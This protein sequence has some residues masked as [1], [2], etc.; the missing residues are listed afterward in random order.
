MQSDA[1]AYTNDMKA[2]ARRLSQAADKLNHAGTRAVAAYLFGLAA[3]CALKALAAGLP[4]GTAE[5][6]QYTH[7]PALRT[8]LRQLQ[9]GR[10]AAPLR[11]LVESD[12]F[13]NQW[14]VAI[15]YACNEDIYDKPIDTWREQ[16]INAV[17]LMEEWS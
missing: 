5:A 2:A 16:S 13:M 11:Q 8:A 1:M 17:S 7:F 15:R 14:D 12:S 10:R 6:I 3:E 9:C 4:G